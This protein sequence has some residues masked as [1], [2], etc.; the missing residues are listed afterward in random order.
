MF[1]IIQEPAKLDVLHALTQPHAVYAQLAIILIQQF[2]LPV[3]HL[4]MH[5]QEQQQ[6][7]ADA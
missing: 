7:A 2:A 1:V 4:V 6:L 3:L 5:V